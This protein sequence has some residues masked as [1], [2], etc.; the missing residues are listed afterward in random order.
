MDGLIISFITLII[1]IIISL[2]IAFI[3]KLMTFMLDRFS[4]PHKE[5]NQ[6]ADTLVFSDEADIAAVIAIAK[7]QK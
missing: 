6:A 2:F 5:P 1:T 4:N 7:S 3:V